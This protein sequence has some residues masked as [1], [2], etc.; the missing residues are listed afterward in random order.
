VIEL[1]C[2]I[3]AFDIHELLPHFLSQ[4]RG[5]YEDEGLRVRLF[6][7]TFTAVD[8]FPKRDYFQVACGGAFMARRQGQPFKVV[9]ASA[10]RPMFWMH[11]VPEIER[12]EDLARKRV[13]TYPPFA[14]PHFFHRLVLES[15]GLDPD[16]DLSFEA[17][18]DDQARLAFLRT[19]EVQAAALSSVYSPV[20]LQRD[21]FRTLA[22]F[23]DHVTMVTTGI[24]THERVLR[25]QPEAIAAVVRCFRRALED[26]HTRPD[27]VVPVIA[28]ALRESEEVAR[29]TLDLV[30]PCFTRD[31]QVSLEVLQA[32]IDRLGEA[33]GPGEPLDAT[34]LY[35]FSLLDD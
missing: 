22:L 15:H 26:I 28:D 10:Y 9:F 33:M 3:M 14:P 20:A 30:R 7:R 34:E 31:G 4:R 2:G 1:E 13:A 19:G 24:A 25:E 16:R 6:D 29:R 27:L 21:G 11:S 5:Y 12:I 8:R 35:D 17:V 18:R 32:A 23:G